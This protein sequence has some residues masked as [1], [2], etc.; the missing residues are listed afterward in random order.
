M[1]LKLAPSDVVSVPGDDRLIGSRL[2]KYTSSDGESKQKPL[3]AEQFEREYARRSGLS[4]QKLREC[5]RVVRS[6][7]CGAIGC[8]GWQSVS[9]DHAAE[10]DDLQKP[11][12]R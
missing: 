1:L 7:D 10:I 2:T 5:G 3:S 12:A 8:F 9:R 11:W 6:C 4:V